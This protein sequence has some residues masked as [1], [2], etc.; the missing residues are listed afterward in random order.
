MTLVIVPLAAVAASLRQSPVYEASADVLLRYQSLPSTLSGITDP[1]SY[2]YFIDPVRSTDTQLQIAELPQ[3]A[4]RVDSALRKRGI[5]TDAG[6]AISVESVTDTDLLRFTAE[7]GDQRTATA[8][9]GEYARQFTR[10]HEELDTS[11]ITSAIA[12][13]EK[14]IATLQTEDTTRARKEAG[15]LRSKADQLETLQTLQTSNAVVVRVPT[16]A[17]KIRPTPRKFGELGIVLGLVLGIGFA[18]LREAF[19]TRLRTAEQIS[20]TLKL[21]LLGRLPAPPRAL[22]KNRQLIMIEQPSSVGADAFRRLRMNIEFA[23]IDKPSQVMMFTSAL[24][25]E[26]K[27]TTV[28]NLAVA[29]ALA[30]KSVAVADL[31]LRRPTVA[32]FFEIGREHPGLTNVVLGDTDIDTALK[33]ITLDGSVRADAAA[34]RTAGTLYVLPAGVL[35]PDPGE[36]V[37][38][39][40][41]GRVL[42]ALRERVEVILLDTPPLLAVGDALTIARYT[43]AIVT[44]VRAEQA[45][46]PVTGE[47]S[48][49]LSR[50]PAVKLGFVLAGSAGVDGGSGYYEYG[51]QAYNREAQRSEYIS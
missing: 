45:R 46:R 32:R 21:P 50:L 6:G 41:V 1:N 23:A 48:N 12:K 7:T 24:A 20:A 11:S 27:S 44:L 16:G 4:R 9:A 43:D 37:G 19:D 26:G 31:D 15:E 38:L 22:E 51:Y 49:V 25:E 3:L 13:L 30:G 28:C 33:P 18:F 39:D 36:F 29:M 35:P 5:T 42:A 17:A 14:R 8:I 34:R 40:G 2:S 47:L 10:Y